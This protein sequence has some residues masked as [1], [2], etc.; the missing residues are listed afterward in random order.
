MSRRKVVKLVSGWSRVMQWGISLLMVLSI[1]A[2]AQ[3]SVADANLA[4]I[5]GPYRL[6]NYC[7]PNK[8]ELWVG[9]G[10]G[11]VV[12]FSEGKPYVEYYLADENQYKPSF[13]GIYFNELSAGWVVG[14]NG[15]IF[16]TMDNGKKWIKQNSGTQETLRAITCVDN[17]RCWAVGSDGVI[18][19]TRNAGEHWRRIDCDIT[20]SLEAVEFVNTTIGWAVGDDGL[21]LHT[22]D[23]GETWNEQRVRIGCDPEC[24]KGETGNLHAV[25][26]VNPQLGWVAGSNGI[27]RTADGGKTW[28]MKYIKNEFFIGLVSHDGKNV[29]AVNDGDNYFSDD[30][31]RTWQGFSEVGRK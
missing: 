13:H 29:W 17:A 23:G 5:P 16:H 2:Q 15:S 8:K 9:G 26:F 18:L 21:V 27:A 22:K 12:H 20:E 30:A 10:H 25:K 6:N 28:E 11:Q 31:G 4:G 1:S 3:D 14:E 19:L 24:A 7:M